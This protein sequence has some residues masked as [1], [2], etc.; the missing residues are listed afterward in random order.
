MR[1]SVFYRIASVLLLLF[2]VGH[3][4]GFRQIDP[5]WKGVDAV[6]AS[7]QAVHFD[8]QGFD[9]TY[10]GFFVGTGLLVTVFLLFSALLAWQWGALS[11]ETLA[12]MALL[13]WGFAFCYAA[14]TF[15]SWK[16]FFIIPL[17]FSAV[18]TVCLLAASW[19]SS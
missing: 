14:V 13:R 4:A 5:S 1:S 6:V 12:G 11:K 8:V 15:L 3:T 17:T 2:A 16:Y 7:M 9:R 18:I 19:L 10:Y